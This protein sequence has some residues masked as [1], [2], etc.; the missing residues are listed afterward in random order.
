MT[1]TEYKVIVDVAAGAV[2]ATLVTI[3]GY[4]FDLVK[5]RM[6]VKAY[7]SMIDCVRQTVRN[8]GMFGLYRGSAMPWISHLIKRPIQYP[9]AEYMKSKLTDSE[10][11][12][13]RNYGIGAVNGLVGPVFGTPL[14]VV[15]ISLQT[16]NNSDIKNSREYIRDNYR[17]NGI[18]G[19]YRGFIPTAMKDSLFGMMF[20][21]TYYS[22]RD[23][24]GSDKWWKNF[25]SGAGAHCLTWFTLIPIDH[26]K[27]KIQRSETRLTILGVIRDSYRTGG[28]R[29]FWKGVIPACLRTIPVS[30]VAMVGY[31]YVRSKLNEVL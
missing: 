6:Q 12:Y 16:S 13:A 7:P 27:T 19:F 25:T 10:S 9:L 26:V 4:P 1:T 31:E 5:S 3:V 23:Y 18:K 8:E 22:S 30:G 15:K 28:I 20:L 14:Q 24:L 29:V 11:S 17:R 2:Q 21:G